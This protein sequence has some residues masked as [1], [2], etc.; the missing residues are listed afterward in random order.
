MLKEIVSMI[1]VVA[2]C[3]SAKLCAHAAPDFLSYYCLEYDW[4]PCTN[5]ANEVYSNIWCD[6]FIVHNILLG[7]LKSGSN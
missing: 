1:S 2:C 7:I 3:H 4:K 5:N 6:L